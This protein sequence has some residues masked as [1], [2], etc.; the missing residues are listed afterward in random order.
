MVP[1]LALHTYSPTEFG[2]QPEEV[3][4]TVRLTG[5]EPAWHQGEVTCLG[6][7]APVGLGFELRLVTG[8]SLWA[9]HLATL[10]LQSRVVMPVFSQKNTEQNNTEPNVGQWAGSTVG[11]W[12]P[13]RAPS[14]QSL[15][16]AL[17]TSECQLI[18]VPGCWTCCGLAGEE[19]V[20][21][22]R[23]GLRLGFWACRP[24]THHGTWGKLF[25]FPS[26]ASSA[27]GGQPWCP[28]HTKIAQEGGGDPVIQARRELEPCPTQSRGSESVGF[29]CYSPVVAVPGSAHS[30]LLVAPCGVGDAYLCWHGSRF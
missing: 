2:R 4:T 12:G 21:T 25:T 9:N 26:V 18:P 14:L 23:A 17:F 13:R 10:P 3:G 8:Y 24:L 27:E 20:W 7:W 29:T 11:V 1:Q 22:L 19:V 28:P 16:I 6:F 15:Y 30:C 5:E